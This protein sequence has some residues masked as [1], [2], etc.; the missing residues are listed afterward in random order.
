MKNVSGIVL[1]LFWIDIL[2]SGSLIKQCNSST[3]TLFWQIATI[4]RK[5]PPV[6]QN[7]L[8]LYFQVSVNNVHFHHQGNFVYIVFTVTWLFIFVSPA[9]T[10]LYK[11]LSPLSSPQEERL[12]FWLRFLWLYA[13]LWIELT[14]LKLNLLSNECIYIFKF[15]FLF[16]CKVCHFFFM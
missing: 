16:F 3:K 6:L 5:T 8:K 15:Y 7:S 4:L 12:M 2:P 9:F 10:F 1:S 14:L 13:L 11:F